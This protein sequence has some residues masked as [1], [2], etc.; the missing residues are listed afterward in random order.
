MNNFFT[1][2]LL[3]TF[4]SLIAQDKSP[5]QIIQFGDT[6]SVNKRSDIKTINFKKYT[7]EF[8]EISTLINGINLGSA[9][10]VDYDSDGLLDIFINGFKI[11]NDDISNATIF[12]NKGNNSFS[13]A[14]VTSF[15]RTIYGDQDWGDYNNDGHI[16][17]IITGTTS[18]FNSEN[19]T[20]IHK[21]LGNNNFS[22]VS[23]NIPELSR[24]DVHW[25]DLDNDGDLD[26]FIMGLDRESNF[27]ARIYINEGNDN[28]EQGPDILT[29]GNGRINFN[30][31]AS[32]WA[33][34]DNDGDI[35]GVLGFS[36][37]TGGYGVKIFENNGQMSFTEKETSIPQLN[38][39]TLDL[40]DFNNDNLIDIVISGNKVAS[41]SSNAEAAYLVIMKNNGILNFE[42]YYNKTTGT[43]WGSIDCGD[44]NNDGFSD[45]LINGNG[46]RTQGSFILE[47]SKD[48]DFKIKDLNL[49]STHSGGAH[50]GR[51]SSNNNLDIYIHGSTSGSSSD[52]T[53]NVF[54]NNTD[55][56]NM[57]P[58]IPTNLYYEINENSFN[59]SW[60]ASVDDKTGTNGIYYNIELGTSSSTFDI[61][62]GQS[63]DSGII[64]LMK[65]GNNGS[66]TSF[67]FPI[68]PN[69]TLYFRVQAIDNSFKSSPFSE[70][71]EIYNPGEENLSVNTVEDTLNL[72]YSDNHISMKNICNETVE[73][74][75][76]SIDGR[77][78]DRGKIINKHEEL[79]SLES[80]IYILI[81]SSNKTIKTKK[82]LIK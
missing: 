17:L 15:T 54:L 48:H 45:V 46:N 37:K 5:K 81:V 19:I 73:W 66:S 50:W 28:F 77:I 72:S 18:G 79:I 67:T 36:S 34:L 82:I 30:V 31:N 78:I 38:Y 74:H 32:V 1:I 75:I 51:L 7:S 13:K 52:A 55:V 70:V 29:G 40:F 56:S 3:F 80:G 61:V 68:E 42:E 22:E 23:H 21:N 12:H 25:E 10:W 62:N 49:T 71:L 4:Y 65:I 60:P 2:A 47:N 9:Q 35:D 16:D 39:A 57:P 59:V 20:E 8:T 6:L 64:K 27:L 41:V 63:T 43:Y 76:I 14:D 26:I 44:Y 33:D 69:K 53:S 11:G 58:T 24:S